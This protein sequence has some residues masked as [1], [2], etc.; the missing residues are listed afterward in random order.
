MNGDD[1]AA[2]KECVEINKLDVRILFFHRVGHI[3][4]T[5]NHPRTEAVVKNI[6]QVTACAAE[7]VESKCH[8]AHVARHEVLALRPAALTYLAVI[9]R[10]VARQAHN[11]GSRHVGQ[12]LRAEAGQIQ[13]NLLQL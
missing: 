4:I 7:A 3:G 12:L 8:L 11:H 13:H 10:G 1:V 5:G 2:L 9:I 6:V